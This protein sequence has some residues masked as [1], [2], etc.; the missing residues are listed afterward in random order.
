VTVTL[1]VVAALGLTWLR[2]V[3]SM[4]TGVNERPIGQARGVVWDGRVFLTASQLQRYFDAKGISYTQW[5]RRHPALFGGNRTPVES[6]ATKPATV[7][8]S[9][10]TER[11]TAEPVVTGS[12]SKSLTA[13]LLT[14]FLVSSSILLG[15]SALVPSRHAPSAVQRLYANSD[16]RTVVFVAATAMLV[17]LG[18]SQYMN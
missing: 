1:V 13:T 3:Q 15:G 6:A 14:I 11:L 9:E 4:S 2:V 16:R 12:S 7:P 17:G 8:V 5:V 18:L 10:S